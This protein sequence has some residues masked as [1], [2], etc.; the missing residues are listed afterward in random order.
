MWTSE[1]VA[2]AYFAYLAL[3]CWL[4]PI[5]PRR[6]AAILAIAASEVGAILWLPRTG[7]LIVR[8]WAPAATILV[9][10]YAS[11]LLFVAPSLRFEAWLV[12]WD[13]RL[14]G[15]PTT[16]FAR[17][18]RG[19]L[20]ILEVI[21]MGCFIIIGAGYLIL[22]L[23][24]HADAADAY[25]TI[26]VAAEFGSFAPLAFAQT[27]PPWAIERKPLLTD[28]AIHELATQM[29]QT[30]TIGA[31]TFPSGHVA[32]SLAVAVAVGRTMP[33]TGVGLF[34]L[35]VTI[36]LATIVGRYHYVIDAFAGAA[37]VAALWAATAG[38]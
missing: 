32:G 30:F 18:P 20:A 11:G 9:G 17:W 37:L 10:Y 5:A 27:R 3:V 22:T 34:A 29:V 4:R 38:V 25:W 15:D 7:F 16:R 13:R 19:V 23:N 26:V 1:R 8:Q 36:A 21:Y 2:I 12:A 33:A 31:N 24:G 28:R 35:A 6:R 14:L